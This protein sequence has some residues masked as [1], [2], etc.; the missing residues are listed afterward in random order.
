M[1]AKYRA[2]ELMFRLFPIL[3]KRLREKMEPHHV[4]WL[5]KLPSRIIAS[6]FDVA[7]GFTHNNP[8]FKAYA[9]HYL[10]HIYAFTA[11]KLGM[12]NPAATK[13]RKGYVPK[14]VQPKDDFSQRDRLLEA[15]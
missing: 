12:K 1:V 6:V 8:E 3:P 2:Y 7:T 11:R 5:P 14:Q 15:S 10:F 9:M 13:V 4:K